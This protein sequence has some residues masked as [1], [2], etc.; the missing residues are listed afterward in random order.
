MLALIINVPYHNYTKPAT[1]SN[2]SQ[3]QVKDDESTVNLTIDKTCWD[4]DSSKLFFKVESYFYSEDQCLAYDTLIST[5]NGN[6]EISMLSKGDYVYTFNES[7]QKVELKRIE[8]I[9]NHSLKEVNNTYYHLFFGNNKS[10]KATWNHR[11]YI[12]GSYVMARDLRVGQ[13]LLTQDIEEV[14][15]IRIEL[16]NEEGT[17]WDI[18]VDGNHNFFA[19]DILT[20]NLDTRVEWF[21]YNGS[22]VSLR[23][24]TPPEPQVYEEAMW[25]DITPIPNVTSRISPTP[26]YTDDILKGYC[27]ATD[28]DG[29]N[30]TYSWRWYKDGMLNES[31]SETQAGWCYQETANVS[32]ACGGLDSGLYANTG[33]W[34]DYKKTH[35]GNYS[36]YGYINM[37]TWGYM[38]I[39]YT[40]PNNAMN[41]SVWQLKTGN[42]T[43]SIVIVSAINFRKIYKGVLL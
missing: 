20:H 10:I 35:D 8:N 14:T 36:S 41:T 30:V 40:K 32:T 29:D 13:K 34:T 2:N 31:G 11:F 24:V 9:I 23:E 16:I 25:W 38:Y 28:G 12:N 22:W 33:S 7:S 39:N 15:I 5:K 19:E 26:A 3:W 4:Y 17:T 27:N 43:G 21:C 6:K 18:I 42:A 1:G 37:V